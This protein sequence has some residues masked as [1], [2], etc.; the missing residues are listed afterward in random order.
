MKK[1]LSSGYIIEVD[2]EDAHFLDEYLI[3]TMQTKF[4]NTRYAIV[5]DKTKRT[6]ITLLHRLI[7]NIKDKNIIVDHKNGNGLDCKKINLRIASKSQNQWNRRRSV[8]F[9]KGIWFRKDRN[10]WHLRFLKN[11]KIIFE[12]LYATEAEAINARQELIQIHYK[13]FDG[14]GT[15]PI[16]PW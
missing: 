7:L 8:N 9:T 14:F 2:D 6:Y 5:R 12:K 11:N 10:K 1:T 4:G 15:E 13:E 3:S 16:K